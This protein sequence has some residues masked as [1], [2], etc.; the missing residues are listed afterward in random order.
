VTDKLNHQ[1]L[2][3]VLGMPRAGTTTLYHWLGQHLQ[4]FTPW[5]KE[6]AYFS[7]NFARGEAW[8]RRF[9]SGM[10]DGTMGIDATPEYFMD[11]T[12]RT[13]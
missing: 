13:G 3:I 4:I 11:R 12:S 5:R 6:L 2:A 10:A 1:N 8:Y 7:R 9:Y